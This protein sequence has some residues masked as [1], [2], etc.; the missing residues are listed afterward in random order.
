MSEELKFFI[1]L[2]AL[3]NGAFIL[4]VAL[5]KLIYYLKGF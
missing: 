1:F 5:S 3:V 4:G 2:N